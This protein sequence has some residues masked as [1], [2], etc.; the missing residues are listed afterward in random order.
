MALPMIVKNLL[1]KDMMKM[2]KRIWYT[3]NYE[4]DIAVSVDKVEKEEK[5]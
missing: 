2:I 5:E 3:I 4:N 1:K